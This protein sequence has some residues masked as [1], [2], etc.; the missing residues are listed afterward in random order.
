[1][2]VRCHR[3]KKVWDYVGKKNPKAKYP[4]YVT[5]SHCRT[6]VKLKEEKKK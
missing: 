6:S 5:C 2:K 4:Q 1:M 3:C